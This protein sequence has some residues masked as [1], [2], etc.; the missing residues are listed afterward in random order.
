[1]KN[2]T[3]VVVTAKCKLIVG[4]HQLVKIHAADCLWYN[5]EKIDMINTLFA[6]A[7]LFLSSLFN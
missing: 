2:D 1:M 7:A 4:W 5:D 6:F 3:L